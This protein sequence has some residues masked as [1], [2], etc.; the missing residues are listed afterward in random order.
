MTLEQLREK[1]ALLPP[2]ELR[3]LMGFIISTSQS[4][5][6]RAKIRRKM[7]DKDP[8]HWMTLEQIQARLKERDAGENE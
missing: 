4:E 3:H 6:E 7:D 1:I 2:K 8:S 5:E